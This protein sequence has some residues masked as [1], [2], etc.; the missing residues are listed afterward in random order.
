[1][2][3]S[4]ISPTL[5]LFGPPPVKK[6]ISIMKGR[7]MWEEAGQTGRLLPRSPVRRLPPF[8]TVR[9]VPAVAPPLFSLAAAAPPPAG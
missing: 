6:N 7:N 4:V 9:P 3:P 8:P 2:W 5:A 1:M